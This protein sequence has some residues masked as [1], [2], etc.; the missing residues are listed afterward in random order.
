[1]PI[2]RPLPQAATESVHQ[3]G[4]R[5]LTFVLATET[6]GT[7]TDADLDVLEYACT[8]ALTS[9]VLVGPPDSR[10]STPAQVY[11]TIENV[12]RFVCVVRVRR[13]AETTTPATPPVEPKAVPP[14]DGGI[15]TART[16]QPIVRP[17]S[18]T[19][20]AVDIAF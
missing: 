15:T 16:P 4:A 5:L 9:R 7:L 11:D 20:A 1:M 6:Y 13:A 8:R 10:E 18:G 2:H 19:A 14:K 12:R 17:P 3:Y